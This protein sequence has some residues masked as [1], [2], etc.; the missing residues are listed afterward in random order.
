M[1]HWYW[2]AVCAAPVALL[3]ASARLAKGAGVAVLATCAITWGAIAA[4]FTWLV[5]DP[6]DI[7]LALLLYF[8]V[9]PFLTAAIAAVAA[10]RIMRVRGRFVPA[11]LLATMGWVVGIGVGIV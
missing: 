4:V 7:A 8:V 2:L 3:L 9:A 6:S 1:G 5:G 11:F 10:T